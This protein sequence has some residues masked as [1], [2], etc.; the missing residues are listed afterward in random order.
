MYYDKRFQTDPMFPL[1]AFNHE[2]IKASSTAGF[3]M[4]EK[5]NFAN[6]SRRLLGMNTDL[7]NDM[8]KR[9][10]TDKSYLPKSDEEKELYQVIRDLDV[11]GGRVTGSLTRKKYMRSELWSLLA[12]KGAPS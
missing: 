2:Q 5:K 3:L 8:I 4:T 1:I 10:Q 9:F 12:Y 6:I 11:V 7:L